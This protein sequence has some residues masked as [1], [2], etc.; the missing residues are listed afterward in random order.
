MLHAFVLSSARRWW[1][2]AIECHLSVIRDQRMR[3]QWQFAVS[4][5]H[6]IVQYID[7]YRSSLTAGSRYITRAQKV[8]YN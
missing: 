8:L 3:S 5:A 4:R 1:K 6:D 7:A 2:F